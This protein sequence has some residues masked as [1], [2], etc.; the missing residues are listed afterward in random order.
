MCF[1]RFDVIVTYRISVT[2]IHCRTVK[3]LWDFYQIYSFQFYPADIYIDWTKDSN[4]NINISQE[5]AEE[6]QQIFFQHKTIHY[7]SIEHTSIA[8]EYV[9]QVPANISV[10]QSVM[11]DQMMN[12]APILHTGQAETIIQNVDLSAPVYIITPSAPVTIGIPTN[13]NT[14]PASVIEIPLSND[15]A[16]EVS[17][18]T[19]TKTITNSKS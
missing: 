7:Q 17:D 14:I 16:N 2:Q 5:I 12:Y 4:N 18:F 13:E 3:W 6:A 1:P 10:M 19:L 9:F 11:A 8:E 15:M